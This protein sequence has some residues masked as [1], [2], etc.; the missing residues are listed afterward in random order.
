MR[1]SH[2]RLGLLAAVAFV[3]VA[4]PLSGG[5]G[6]AKDEVVVAPGQPL[7]I[8]VALPPDPS[9]ASLAEGMRNAIGIAVGAHA[10]VHGFAVQLNTVSAPCFTADAVAMNAASAQSVVANAQNVAVIGHVCSLAFAN[11]APFDGDCVPPTNDA[12]PS[13]LAI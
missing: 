11:T 6:K 13:A 9:I 10:T 4:A 3:L 1:R 2:P 7:Q 5:S 8:A 12:S